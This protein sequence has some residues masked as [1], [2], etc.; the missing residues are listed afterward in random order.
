[1]SQPT[2]RNYIGLA[3]SPHDPAL[4]IINA[5]GEVVFAEACERYLQN[6]RAWNTVPDDLVRIRRLIEEHC[7]AGAELVVA[8]SWRERR[9]WAEWK[10]EKLFLPAYRRWVKAHHYQTLKVLRC[11]LFVN[12]KISGNNVSWQSSFPSRFHT[13]VRRTYDHHLTHAVAACHSSPFSSA[14][15]AVIDG[16]GEGFK[17]TCFYAYQDGRLS[18]IEEIKPSCFASLG[19][20]YGF[21]CEACGFDAMRGEEWK[22]MGLASYGKLDEHIYRVLKSVIHVDKGQLI[23]PKNLRE[24]SARTEPLI[25][26]PKAPPLQA[27]DL[28]F[29][30]QL[31][32]TEVMVELLCCL[33]SLNIS[34]NLVLSGGCALNSA[35]NGLLLEKTPFKNL[36]VFAAPGDDGNAIGAALCAYHEDH[37]GRKP[38]ETIQSPY[39][40]TAMS[41]ATLNKIIKFGKLRDGRDP[42]R[43]M[44]EQ[45][46]QALAE[47]KIVGWVQGRAE[48]GPRALGN[49]SILA[50]PRSKDIKDVLNNRVKFREQFR[51]FAPAILH[52]HGPAYFENYQESPY[53]ERTLRFRPDVVHK[54]PGVVHVDG[55]GRLQTVKREWNAPFYDLIAAFYR[56]T[57]VPILLNTSF[58]VMG[59][60]IIHSAED[61]LAVFFTSGLDL[62]V[63]GDLLLDKEHLFGTPNSHA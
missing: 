7:E 40:G 19:T 37:P 24:L 15:C 39:L 11:G 26:D 46:A 17:S 18:R 32:F 41:S 8:T 53:M 28:A 51:P 54:I 12:N 57:G 3:T 50:D 60:P 44:C 5:D 36:F 9:L 29:T 16:Y 42:G 63:I 58:N 21:L 56:I 43:P 33:H 14:V 4:A 23:S 49:R 25:R 62:L 47:G 10:F 45:V 59:K 34:D 48:F 22:V 38:K 2:V 27:A 61:A 52:E 30:G 6:K 20:F 55:T 35:C 1:M 13:V 31:V